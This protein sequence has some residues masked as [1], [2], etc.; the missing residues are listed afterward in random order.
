MN[1]S[2]GHPIMEYYI[3]TVRGPNTNQNQY[4]PITHP[5]L[6]KEETVAHTCPKKG[7]VAAGTK[8]IY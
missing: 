4:L 3:E 6:F 1:S 5:P 7:S 2:G 8:T